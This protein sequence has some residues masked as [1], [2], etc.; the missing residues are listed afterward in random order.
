MRST[1]KDPLDDS[2]ILHDIASILNWDQDDSEDE[3]S[4]E[5]EASAEIIYRDLALALQI[6][7]AN[8]AFEP[9]VYRK[10]GEFDSR[11]WVKIC[12]N[13]S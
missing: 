6:V 10:L 11:S 4:P 13:Q 3:M 8:A 2:A 5:T 12:R 9:G 7:L 1:T